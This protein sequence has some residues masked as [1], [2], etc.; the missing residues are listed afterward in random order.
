MLTINNL[1]INYQRPILLN[2]SYQIQVGQFYQIRSENYNC[3]SSFLWAIIS[4][5][6]FT[7]VKV[8][9]D[10]HPHYGAKEKVFFFESYGLFSL[11]FNSLDYLRF[12]RRQRQS[13]ANLIDELVFLGISEYTKIPIHKYMQVMKQKLMNTMY[14]ISGATYYLMNEII[15]HLDQETRLKVF[16]RVDKKV[17]EQ[18]KAIMVA[19]HQDSGI[20]VSNMHKM[21]FQKQMIYGVMQ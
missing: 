13:H 4:R 5:K 2:F 3:Q 17:S 8:F 20:E 12:V 14:F 15:N 11:S 1:S 21:A 9:I 6:P 16:A 7:K 10:K 18:N 19:L